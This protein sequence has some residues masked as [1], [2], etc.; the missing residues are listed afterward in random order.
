MIEVSNTQ[1]MRCEH[2]GCPFP[3]IPIGTGHVTADGHIWC[4]RCAE[5]PVPETISQSAGAL[6]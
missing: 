3:V 5:A 2:P 6:E 4:L 1:V